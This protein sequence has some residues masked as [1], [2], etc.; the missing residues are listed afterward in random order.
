MAQ[1]EAALAACEVITNEG[2]RRAA[3]WRVAMRIVDSIVNST[4]KETKVRVGGCV[5]TGDTEGK[6]KRGGG[7][8]R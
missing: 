5:I 3:V 8:G 2:I 1:V 7:D 4:L 6:K